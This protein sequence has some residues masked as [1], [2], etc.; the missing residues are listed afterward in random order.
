[1]DYLK[2]P[3]IREQLLKLPHFPTRL[4]AVVFRLWETVPAFRI[5]EALEIRERDILEIADE[6]GLPEQRVNPDWQKRGYITI[7]RSVWHLLPYENLLRLLNMN[8]DE[9]ALILKEDD[10]LEWKL[11]GFK[12][13]CPSIRREALDENGRSAL[14]RIKAAVRA[15]FSDLFSADAPFSFFDE[16]TQS[17]TNAEDA[18]GIRLVYSYQGLYAGALESDTSFSYPDEL[19]NQYSQR[20]VNAIWLPAV[21]YQ[22]VPFTFDESYSI[23]YEKRRERLRELISRAERYG[24]KVYLYLNEPRCMPIGFFDKHPELLGATTTYNGALCT[25]L[26]KTMEYLSRGVRELCEAVSGL[27]G[28]FL[29]TAS[30]NLTHCKSKLKEG[31][32][33]HCKRCEDTAP[34]KLIS[35]VIRVISHTAWE[36]DP[37]L[38]IIA[39]TWAWDSIMDEDEI[40]RCIENIPKD[41][42]IQS[43]SEAQMPYEIGGIKGSVRD[44]SISIPGPSAL[45]R[46]VWKYAKE[47]G[48]EVM[49]KVQVNVTW[50]CSTLP[51]LPV[52]DLIRAHIIGLREVGVEH[53][54]LSWTLGGYPS[55]NMKIAAQ[56]LKNPSKDE[57]QRILREEW[58]EYAEAVE[59]AATIFSEAFREFPFHINTLYKGPQNPG[60]SNLLYSEPS[61]FSATMTCYSYDDLDG[62]RSIYP[63]DVYINQLR[64]LSGK[65][66]E[67]LSL[68]DGM[69]KD[70]LFR[71]VAEVAYV[72]FYSSYLQ[73][74]FVDARDRGD[75]ETM[76][77]AAGEEEKN[78]LKMYALMQKCNL[79]GFEA[80]NHYYYSK[81]MLAEKVINCRYILELYENK[82]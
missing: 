36:V 75:R 52:F 32:V 34:S 81:G 68:T 42:I 31:T 2:L 28:F 1:M 59:R 80:A 37:D 47:L 4:H 23:G 56:T 73:A 16:Q 26:D 14:R 78:A 13:Y 66:K 50:E 3:K 79:F 62:W 18:N 27:G 38:K 53:L 25:A 48:H 29:I 76:I 12:P 61:G 65:W 11:G 74:S 35:D 82:E 33:C 7:I 20:G 41:V 21:L 58:G 55:V 69:P 57:Y 15:D 77:Y 44:Y 45:A 24:I 49:A 30:E 8:E 70:D 46:T 10:F 43:N 67:G 60:A 5:A 51:Y 72:V 71:L 19:L 40:K 17:G 64:L 39:W 22:L 6:M 63:R 9:L 54:M